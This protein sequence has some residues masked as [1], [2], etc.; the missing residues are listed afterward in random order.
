MDMGKVGEEEEEEEEESI[1]FFFFFHSV[2]SIP[3]QVNKQAKQKRRGGRDRPTVRIEFNVR[4]AFFCRIQNTIPYFS[5]FFG[6]HTWLSYFNCF[7]PLKRILF[8]F[9]YRT[10]RL[11]VGK[12][13]LVALRRHLEENQR[14]CARGGKKEGVYLN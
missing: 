11:V 14:T 2:H 12:K 13:N 3:P 9:L 7:W 6:K 8:R 4:E 1:L 5:I 10:G